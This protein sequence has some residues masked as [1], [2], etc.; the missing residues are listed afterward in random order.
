MVE[1]YPLTMLRCKVWNI[2]SSGQ[3]LLLK[4]TPNPSKSSEE[5]FVTELED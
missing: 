1:D 3:T 5:S 4:I 2:C